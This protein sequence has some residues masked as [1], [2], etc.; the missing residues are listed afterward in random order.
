M[1]IF[2]PIYNFNYLYSLYIWY[3]LKMSVGYS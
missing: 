3:T 2:V 1:Y